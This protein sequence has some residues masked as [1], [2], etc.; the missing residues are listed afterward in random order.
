MNGFII[1]KN[2]S[3]LDDFFNKEDLQRL[4]SGV[5]ISDEELGLLK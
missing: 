1:Q 5:Y 4:I 2:K 3:Y